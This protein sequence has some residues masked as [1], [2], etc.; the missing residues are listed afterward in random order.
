MIRNGI[1]TNPNLDND[2]C[3]VCIDES[4]S[5]RTCKSLCINT[6]RG[7]FGDV[8]TL[9]PQYEEL[10]R[11]MD[12]LY[13]QLKYIL[14]SRYGSFNQ[15]ILTLRQLLDYDNDNS[16]V[17]DNPFA[18]GFKDNSNFLNKF[19]TYY[20]VNK[21]LS[22]ILSNPDHVPC[23]LSQISTERCWTGRDGINFDSD[24]VRPYTFRGQKVNP[25]LPLTDHDPN[26]FVVEAN[27][28]LTK[29][30]ELTRKVDKNDIILTVESN[31][32]P[33]FSKNHADNISFFATFL[34]HFAY[35]ALIL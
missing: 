5:L 26:P 24:Y 6:I 11:V 7:C 33:N 29:A 2:M 35:F 12:K 17:R 27:I 31:K 18:E 15:I 4:S 14:V 19:P 32:N 20:T 13:V 28:T 30:L 16:C 9:L 21:G 8:T 10:L 25:I 1:S 3:P 23:A 22:G 34:F